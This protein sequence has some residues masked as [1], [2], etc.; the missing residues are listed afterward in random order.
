MSLWSEKINSPICQ[1]WNVFLER[2]KEDTLNG[3]RP[4]YDGVPQKTYEIV[5]AFYKNDLSDQDKVFL[6]NIKETEKRLIQEQFGDKVKPRYHVLQDTSDDPNK[7][8][9]VD[10]YIIRLKKVCPQSMKR[11]P[12][13]II[14]QRQNKVEDLSMFYAGCYGRCQLQLKTYDYKGAKGVS[15]QLLTAQF[16]KDGDPIVFG[17]G[18]IGDTLDAIEEYDSLSDDLGDL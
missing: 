9:P 8:K 12:V 18:E 11:I 1:F 10:A 6:K 14:D 3:E 15:A 4:V 2:D 5:L 16:A 13:N 7:Y 17:G